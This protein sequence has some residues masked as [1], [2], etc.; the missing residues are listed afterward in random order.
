MKTSKRTLKNI[1]D[2]Y[3]SSNYPIL[4]VSFHKSLFCKHTSSHSLI[5]HAYALLANRRK[6]M[7]STITARYPLI[8][9]SKLKSSLL[10]FTARL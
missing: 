5:M 8:R 4:E 2:S 10:I 6:Q 1:S 3:I 9:E 7:E